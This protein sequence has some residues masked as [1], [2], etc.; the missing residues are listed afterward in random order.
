MSLWPGSIRWHH[1]H[2]LEMDQLEQSN[3]KYNDA[4]SEL[5]MMMR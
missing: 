5:S 1:V 4:S 3:L 2:T